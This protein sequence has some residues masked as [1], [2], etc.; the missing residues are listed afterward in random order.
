MA[1]P[2]QEKKRKRFQQW[3][4]KKKEKKKMSAMEPQEKPTL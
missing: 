4:L 1:E 2:I 3:N